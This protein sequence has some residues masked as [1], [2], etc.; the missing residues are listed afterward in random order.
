MAAIIGID[1]GGS[2]IKTGIVQQGQLL[3]KSSLPMDK[4]EPMEK[5]LQRI[6]GECSKIC[7]AAGLSLH[8]V[9]A[10]GMGIPGII[11]GDTAYCPNLPA[12]N[13]KKPGLCMAELLSLPVVMG[14]DADCAALY[15]WK[16]GALKGCK[17]A[18]LLTLG[19]GIGCGI[20]A[21]KRL[22]PGAGEAGHMVIRRG[23]WHCACGKKGCFE[24]Y[25]G[26]SGLRRMAYEAGAEYGL[27]PQK[28]FREA[29]GGN[30]V[31]I[32]AVENYMDY[33]AEGILNI[34]NLLSPGK[35]A[36]GGGIAGAKD[37]LFD[38]VKKRIEAHMLPGK[39]SVCIVPAS[40]G[41]DA[42]LL[43]AAMLCEVE[44]N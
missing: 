16:E 14:N 9:A 19:T 39:K 23:G 43:G 38:G 31:Y 24:A 28:I 12:W 37:I 33:L 42:G 10:A 30:Q 35:V 25:C 7:A 34:I 6:A 17:N 2:F 40:A 3:I 29:Q 41:N 18:V 36:L 26:V 20:I 13:G 32:K 11:E 22:L 44:K 1:A 21:N 27:E 15:E 5:A 4:Q 8:T